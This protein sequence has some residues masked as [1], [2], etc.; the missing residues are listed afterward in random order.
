V[1]TDFGLAR[2]PLG[3]GG[4]YAVS[5]A[6]SAAGSSQAAGTPDYMAPELWKGEKPSSASDV[7]ALGVILYELVANQRPYKSEI[8]WQ[9]RQKQKL[10]PVH[11]AWSPTLQR[12][13]DADPSKRFQDAAD[14]GTALEPSRSRLRW[15]AAAA[16]V[17]LAVASGVVTYQRATA[18]KESWRLAMLPIESSSDVA[19]L[20]GDLSQDLAGQL[21][22]L[23]GGSV[24]RLTFVDASHIVREAQR[25]T[26]TLRA[27]LTKE[28]NKLLLHAVLTDARTGA[29]VKDWAAAYPPGEVRRYAPVALAGMVTGTL[30]LP[31]LA[32]AAVNSAAA[33][34][35]WAGVWY[36]RQNSTLDSALGSLQRAVTEDPD[37][38]LPYAALAEAQWYEY[39]FTR[40]QA[41]LDHARES[42]RQAEGRNPDVPGAH[43]VEGYL[44]Y[45]E[46]FYEQAVPE[47]ERAIELQPGNAMAHM[48]LGKTYED[49]AQLDKALAEFLKASEVEPQ[50]FATWQNL[51]AY[52]QNRSNFTEMARYHK[53]AVDLARNEPNLHRNLGAAFIDL[54]R[55]HDAETEYRRS[56]DL[57]KTQSAEYD[58]GLT[59]MYENR[60]LEAVEHFKEA[61]KFDSQQFFTPRYLV[62]M[63]L[64][65]AE[66]QLGDVAAADK[67]DQEG[68]NL[69]KGSARRNSR[70]G[71]DRA[72]LGYF[73]A[74]L[75]RDRRDAEDAEDDINFALGLSKDHSEVR[76]TGVLAY[77][78]LY[79]KFRNAAYR[80]QTLIILRQS[81]SDQISDVS[82]WPDLRDLHEDPAFKQLLSGTLQLK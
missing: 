82:R 46:G 11:H 47:F 9:E 57:G 61:L 71:E 70:D 56:L 23:K 27:T 49:N 55:F 44:H 24:A 2:R 48:Y 22:R 5:S 16:A 38:P 51:G 40:D 52:Y 54:G 12:C 20:A 28:N 41:W 25:A 37:S 77:E 78:E 45:N 1:I 63:Y 21:G 80:D 42:L 72:Y 35:Y 4:D 18:P 50:Y 74:A 76:W 7:Y 75:S 58:L 36:T 69:A 39:R 67:D 43:R 60:A 30:R 81:G 59:L 34:D 26:H 8:P 3:P 6:A 10:T 79:R 13:L 62:L 19:A 53:K 31:P 73:K 29:N 64:G 65:I 33:K 14:V 68:L 15:A 66:R 32:V 17:A